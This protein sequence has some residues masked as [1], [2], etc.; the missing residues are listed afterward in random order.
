[1]GND[2]C[3]DTL[4]VCGGSGLDENRRRRQQ[5][6][7]VGGCPRR[8][9]SERCPRLPK[10]VGLTIV[11][12]NL[13][14]LLPWAALMKLISW[15]VN[16]IRAVLKKGFLDFMKKAKPDVICLQETK[17]E[18]SQVE[19]ELP[20]Y[21]LHWNWAE[22]KGYSGTATFSRI[23]PLNVTTGINVAEHDR[24]GRVLTAEFKDFFL[25][26]VYVPNSQR[27]L[28]RLA[29]RLTWEKDFLAFLRKL[30]KKK[31]V[32]YCGDLNVAH[33]ENDLTN[34]KQNEGQHGFT[35][36]EREAFDRV[37][38]AGFVDTFRQFT[39]GKGHYTWWAP[40]GGA[41]AKNIGWRIDYF[42]ASKALA[43][44]VKA[45]KILPKVMGSDHC[46]IEIEL[47]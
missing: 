33:T 43:P 38:K 34:A 7:A 19:I 41:R 21:H 1:L 32:L 16:G 13:R 10:P 30:E 2:V 46:P 27:T 45:S 3:G 25:V 6:A 18:P 12:R 31:P 47:E 8:A 5:P 26:N 22:K 9:G 17:A 14:T 24:E 44:R 40:F 35:P 11:T 36:E 37:L 4:P 39:E 15:N 42:M 29:Y 28:D 20:G 23:A